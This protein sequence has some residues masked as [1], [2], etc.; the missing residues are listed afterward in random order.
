[1][2][3]N[4]RCAIWMARPKALSR[5]RA[6]DRG[7]DYSERERPAQ[8]VKLATLIRAVH[9]EGQLREVVTQFWHDHFNVNATKD[10]QCAA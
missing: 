9:A 4:V 6:G 7:M 10:E 3:P 1:M 8:E 2:S 5:S